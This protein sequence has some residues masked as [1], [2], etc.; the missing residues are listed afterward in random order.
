MVLAFRVPPDGQ[1]KNCSEL[2]FPHSHSGMKVSKMVDQFLSGF[3]GLFRVLS[4]QK[5]VRL[6]IFFSDVGP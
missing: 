5:W 1:L 3:V 6:G 2:F 4:I